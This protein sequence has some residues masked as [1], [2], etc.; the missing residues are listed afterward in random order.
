M[1]AT[2]LVSGT[3]GVFV[4]SAYLVAL[5]LI[6]VWAQRATKGQTLG[7]FFLA[8]RGLGPWVLFLTLFATQYSGNTLV[9]MAGQTYRAG[10]SFIVAV[11]F[12]VSVIGVAMVL[13]PGLHRLGCGPRNVCPAQDVSKES[14]P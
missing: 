11:P 1:S 6:G 10:Y 3:L 14:R 5:L 2:P 7:E 13:A 9:G 8:G 4:V 12:M